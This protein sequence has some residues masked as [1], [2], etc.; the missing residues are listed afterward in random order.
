MRSRKTDMADQYITV[1]QL[2]GELG[3][4]RSNARKYVL[5]LRIETKKQ[6]TP[7]S[8]GQLTLTVSAQQAEFIRRTREEQGYGDSERPIETETGAGYFYVIQLVP[9]LDPDRVKLGFADNVET[10]LAQHRT[11]APTAK[12]LKSWPCKRSWEH[13]AMDAIVSI[14]GKLIL[15]EVFE[16]DNMDAVLKQ[17]DE[18]FTL[19]PR[20]GSE[21][22]LSARSPYQES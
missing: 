2:A 18:F 3:M 5:A 14:G 21:V 22:P 17:G 12:L 6:R 11:S 19:L 20:P 15:N 10:R 16:F 1:K 7:D 9:E 13:A 8:R 4:N